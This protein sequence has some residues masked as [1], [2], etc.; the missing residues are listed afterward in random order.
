MK[1]TSTMCR[2]PARGFASVM[3]IALIVMLGLFGVAL[4][5]ISTT[6]QGGATLDLQGVR[7]Y[8]AARGGAEGGIYQVLRT[9][10]GCGPVNGASFVYGGNLSGFRVSMT[11]LQV[12]HREVS[13]NTTIYSIQA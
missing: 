7:A 12:D 10:G 1:R 13:T 4:A 5:V 9:G 11:C 2:K 6:E 3:A 8:H